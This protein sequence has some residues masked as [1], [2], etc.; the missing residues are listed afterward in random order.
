MT[1]VPKS[2]TEPLSMPPAPPLSPPSFMKSEDETPKDKSE[3]KVVYLKHRW[4]LVG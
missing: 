4:D 2:E 3:P 1:S